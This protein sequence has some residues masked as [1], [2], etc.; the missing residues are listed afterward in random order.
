[1]A[2]SAVIAVAAAVLP[3]TAAHADQVRDLEYWLNDYGFAQAWNTTRGAGVKVAV[4]DTGVDGSVPDLAGAVVGGP[5]ERR[6]R[7]EAG[8]H[9]PLALTPA[10]A[11]RLRFGARLRQLSHLADSV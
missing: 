3:A 9:Q 1:M 6:D 4:I 10:G 11:L 8:R 7:L 5:D 2:A